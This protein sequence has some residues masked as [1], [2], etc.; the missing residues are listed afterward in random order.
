MVLL[1]FIYILFFQNNIGVEK[2]NNF[3]L[4]F[5]C[6]FYIQCAMR[7]KERL[8]KQLACNNIPAHSPG[9][10][11]GSQNHETVLYTQE[12]L[13]SLVDILPC[14]LICFYYSF[15]FSSHSFIHPADSFVMLCFFRHKIPL[16][17]KYFSSS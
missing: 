7:K 10:S 2:N 16:F 3:G 13:E 14:H 17:F 9:V 12:T 6:S 8:I 15:L 11:G 4:T 5:A 1:H